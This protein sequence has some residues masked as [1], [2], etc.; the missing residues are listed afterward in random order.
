[1]KLNLLTGSALLTCSLLTSAAQVNRQLT[2]ADPGVINKEAILYWLEQRGELTVNASDA[3][4]YQAIKRYLGKKSFKPRT[5]P[6]RYGKQQMAI[7]SLAYQKAK[8]SVNK[9]GKNASAYRITRQQAITEAKVLAIMIDFPDHQANVSNYPVSHYSELLYANDGV[10]QDINSVYKYYQAESGGTLNFSGTVNGWVRADSNAADYGA[11]DPENNDDDINVPA[12]IIE[13][14]T[15]AVAEY[16]IDLNDY[17][18]DNDGIIDHVMVFHSSIG[19]EAGGGTLGEDA[20]WSHS[21]VVTDENNLPVTVSGTNKKLYRYTINPLDARIGVVSHEFGHDLGVPD[22]YDVDGGDIGSPVADWSIMASGSWVDGG[23]H[24]S[25]FSPYAKDYF[26][27]R[28]GGNWI[29]Q[30]ELAFDALTSQSIELVSATNHS[31]GQINQVKI[32][33]PGTGTEFSPYAGQYQYYSGE[34]HDLN[35]SLSF[36]VSLPAGSSILTMKA[37]WDIETD[38]DYAVVSVNDT[39]IPG[40]H[41]TEDNPLEELPNVHHY[42]SASSKAVAGAE[43]E[44][45]WVDLIFDLAAYQNQTVTIKIEYITDTYVSEYGLVIDELKVVSNEEVIFSANAETAG[46]ESLAGGFIRTQ[47]W[48]QNP[49]YYFIQLREHDLTDKYLLNEN[50]DHGVLIWYHS[51]GVKDNQV[52]SHP[53]DVLIGVV[54]ADQKPI[55]QGG[56]YRNT[57]FQIS[58]AAFSQYPQSVWVNGDDQLAAVSKFDDTLDYSA[59]YQPASGINLPTLGLTMEITSQQSDSSAAIISLTKSLTAHI[60]AEQHGLTVSFT[61]NDDNAIADTS[62]FWS[63]GDNTNMTGASITHT[64]AQAG[65]YD[66]SVSYQTTN[67]ENTLAKQVVVGET[68]EGDFSVSINDKDATFTPELTG[69]FG[70]YVYRWDFG[71]SSEF[72]SD[73]VP[74]HNYQAYGSYQVSLTVTDDT[75]QSFVFTKEITLESMLTA[76]FSSN[77]NNLVVSFTSIVAGGDENYSYAWNFGDGATST[78]ENPSHTYSVAGSY[79]VTLTVSDGAGQQVENSVSITVTEAVVVTPPSTTSSKSSG[80]GSFGWL[81]LLSA[82]SVCYRVRK[83]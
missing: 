41:T 74:S 32:N 71:D 3:E 67:G 64:Y 42:I 10:A 28:Y 59:P 79:Q 82:I 4:R 60:G 66:V 25:G 45:G 16:D 46:S 20:I 17:D 2:P 50:Y 34:G 7:Q 35:S 68:I 33:L 72:S 51:P 39:V 29:N 19:E 43:G 44:L 14:V 73:A 18:L 58:D 6:G 55:K 62:Y 38:W 53:G 1:M 57:N 80:G 37:H 65:E 70:D 81:L 49:Q 69:G 63:M 13:A 61:V 22:E 52:N 48:S 21:Y 23:A 56:S 77:T 75:L 30:Q 8:Q 26:Q 54:D 40:N 27:I 11:N 12:L 15:K 76:S 47:T 83:N 24:P 9:S 78:E 36:D 5:L 31:A